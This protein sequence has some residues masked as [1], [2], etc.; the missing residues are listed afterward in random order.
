MPTKPAAQLPTLLLAAC[1]CLLAVEATA[2]TLG[3]ARAAV[4]IGR[5]LDVQ[6]PA[7]LN[8]ADGAS[9]CADAEVFHG[10]RRIERAP[11]VRW[12]PGAG[13]QGTLRILTSVAVDEPMVTIYLR[14]G[15]GQSVTRKFV[16]L[17]EPLQEVEAPPPPPPLTRTLPLQIAG[18]GAAGSGAGARPLDGLPTGAGAPPAGDAAAR[19]QA[20]TVPRAAPRLTPAPALGAAPA[21]PARQATAAPK[22]AETRPPPAQP[23]PR[24]RLKLEPLD[25]TQERDPTLRPSPELKAAPTEDLQ[26]R[27]TAAALWDV[28]R[29][30]PEDALR[31]AQRLQVLERDLD[32]LRRQ[33]E[34]NAASLT[35]MREQVEKARNERNML[36]MVGIGLL[37][38]LLA[39]GGWLVMR[40]LQDRQVRRA[41]WF[42]SQRS[43][44]GSLEARAPAPTRAPVDEAP[45]E[46]TPLAAEPP[47]PK[48]QA[49]PAALPPNRGPLYTPPP[50][51]APRN[52]FWNSGDDF[53]PSQ[54]GSIRMVGVEELIDIQDKANFFISL[55]QID[56]AVAI[57]EAHVH[58]QVET[59]PL[60]WLDL[61]ELYHKHGR[62]DDFA[63]LR[64]EFRARFA[65]DV[66]EFDDFD[67]PTGG[68]ENYERALSRIVALWPS[69]K[70]LEVIEESIFRKPG[71]PGSDTFSLEAY[72]ELLL[73]YHIATDVAPAHDDDDEDDTIRRPRPSPP[74][75]AAQAD[76]AH[77]N[78]EPLSA[79]DEQ[80][81]MQLSPDLLLVPPTSSRLGL[82]IDLGGFDDAEPMMADDFGGLE[83]LP[84][85]PPAPAAPRP[86]PA[87]T[88]A[89]RPPRAS[90]SASMEED[91]IP[92]ERHDASPNMIEVDFDTGFFDDLIDQDGKK[93]GGGKSR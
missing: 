89:P 43:D 39:A 90:R 74:K 13:S 2:T 79:A 6:V 31:D 51:P 71:L 12:E 85:E 78:L 72:R 11:V 37:V 76:F 10:D 19:P 40:M 9:P 50:P 32:S 33:T 3:R 58:D 84:A 54:G 8:A 38:L 34:Q 52:S 35:A 36:A 44:M 75:A 91:T 92:I 70:V 61:L 68:L 46:A 41:R 45:S 48:S 24:P 55:G 66:P 5:P 21:R 16:L 59:S 86:E 83:L 4:L 17:A 53:Q 47:R 77:T 65:A 73:L 7:V 29:K 1:G 28:L 63:R 82:D 42:D 81:L 62:R 87:A 25:L 49:V 93:G 67:K 20:V 15:C 60:A 69:R 22:T 23:R 30:A 57:L 14:V 26:A 64:G 80:E 27:Q 56:Q 18:G 88:P